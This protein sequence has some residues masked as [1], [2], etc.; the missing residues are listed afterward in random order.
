[1]STTR[2][3]NQ[4]KKDYK[5]IGIM[6]GTFDPIHYGHL[7][8]AEQIR[9]EYK[10]EKV[11]FIPAGTPPHK[12]NLCVTDSKHRYFMTLLATI[13]NPYF[14]L[15]KIE[16]ENE[17]ISYTIHTIEKLKKIYRKDTEIYFITGADAICE[18]D[19]WKNVNKLTQLCKFIA[20]TRPGLEASQVD[21][22][23][24]ELKEKYDAFIEKIDLPALAISSTDIRNR[25]REG[26]SIKYLLPEPVEYYIYK[27]NLY[28]EV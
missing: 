8:I 19:T 27:N 16:I 6:G 24:R 3:T 12:S 1:M 14:E 26:Q 7:V 10:L 5:R 20:A 23:I 15:S 25:I 28:K 17:E 21:A 9:C 2:N 18:L 22:K 4:S 13:T 11:V